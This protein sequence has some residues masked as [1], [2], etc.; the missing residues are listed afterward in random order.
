MNKSVGYNV[1]KIPVLLQYCSTYKQWKTFYTLHIFK[2]LLQNY[3][4]RQLFY[5]QLLLVKN[6]N[7][8]KNANT[9]YLIWRQC[10]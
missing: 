8:M 7:R 2:Q 9:Y 5:S 4:P 3:I 6:T 10:Y 1:K